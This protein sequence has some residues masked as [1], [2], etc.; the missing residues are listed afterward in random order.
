MKPL[1]FALNHLLAQNA[2]AQKALQAHAGKI[3]A[4]RLASLEF[5][6]SILEDGQ[7]ASAAED[8]GI[9]ARLALPPGA[10]LRF[11][12]EHRLDASPL[13]MSGDH[14]LATTIGKV[15][16]GLRWD[17]EE[18]LSRLIGDIPAHQLTLAGLKIKNELSRQAWSLAGMLAEYWQEEQPL[19]AKRRHLAEFSREVDALRDDAERLAKR[20]AKREQAV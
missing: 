20:V 10:A 3:V 5:R 18:D 16:Q 2:W 6:L 12:V 8:A 17:A 1:V 13:S 14:A 11:L 9:D 15:L 4:L 19:I 7:L